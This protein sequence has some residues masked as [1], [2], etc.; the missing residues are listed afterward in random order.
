LEHL[1][2]GAPGRAG[3]VVERTVLRGVPHE[4]QELARLLLEFPVVDAGGPHRPEGRGLELEPAPEDRGLVLFQKF[5][6]PGL[7]SSRHAH[8]S[9]GGRSVQT[10]LFRIEGTVQTTAE[11]RATYPAGR[12]EAENSSG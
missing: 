9:C 4:P 11:P 5:R 2:R 12:S 7:A 10:V 6:N 8:A 1:A 3:D